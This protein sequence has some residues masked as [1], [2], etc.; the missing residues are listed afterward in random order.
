MNVFVDIKDIIAI[1]VIV[2]ILVC[3]GG[4]ILWG[5]ITEWRKRWA[6]KLLADD[7]IARYERKIKRLECY[8][9]IVEDMRRREAI[10]CPAL[11]KV[12]LEMLPDPNKIS[13][14]SGGVMVKGHPAKLYIPGRGMVEFSLD[15]IADRDDAPTGEKGLTVRVSPTGQ[16]VRFTL[17]LQNRQQYIQGVEV[18][19]NSWYWDLRFSGIQMLSDE[20]FGRII[21]FVLSS[22]VVSQELGIPGAAARIL[23]EF[24]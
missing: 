14:T 10:I 21:D 4:F 5:K 13:Q 17:K 20:G 22:R 19:V 18:Q 23:G 7:D 1:A 16:E 11:L 3:V 9:K 6:R 2:L 15:F 8:E 24:Q 12:M